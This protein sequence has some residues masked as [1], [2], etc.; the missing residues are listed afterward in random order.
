MDPKIKQI[1]D[2]AVANKAS[3]IHMSDSYVPQLR[4]NGELTELSNVNLG[5][6]EEASAMILSILSAEQK[7]KFLESKELDLSL[8]TPEARFRINIYLQRGGVT[9]TLRVVPQEIPRFADL[10]FPEVFNSFLKLNQGFVLVTGPTGSGKSTTVGSIL[11]EINNTQKRHIVTIED[12]IEYIMKP[13]KS[14]ISQ[15]EVGNDTVSFSMALR[16][17]L[18]QDPNVVFVGEMRDLETI[19]SALTIAET[20]HLVF[21]T[22][23]TNSASQT[24]DRI[25]D[26]FPEGMK[27]Q[28]RV[29]MAEVISAVVSQRLIPT[30]DGKRAPAFEILVATSAVKNI[31]REGKTFMIDNVIQT[32]G[33]LGMIGMETSLARLVKSGRVLEEVAMLYALRPQELQNRL[34]SIK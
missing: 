12:P 33:D 14:I 20:G 21:S 22:L 30:V 25:V 24:M 17:A 28:V 9:A 1:L 2:L 11:N 27:D 19:S 5:T 10:N 34:R 26:V 29:Q 6:P 31:I 32:G 18:R 16:S 23:H 8:T 4:I 13:A 7:E 3:D 15:R